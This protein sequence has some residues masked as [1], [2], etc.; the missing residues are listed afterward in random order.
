MVDQPMYTRLGIRLRE[1]R[2]AQN[3]SVRTL[4]SQ[5]GFS[6]SFISNIESETVSP[7]IASLEKIA[8]ALGVTLSE[9][10]S[11]LET[12]PRLIVRR[13]ERATSHSEWSKSS[14]AMLTDSSAGRQ[15]SAVEVT[16]AP[17]GASGSRAAPIAH[18]LFALVLDGAAEL[19][20]NRSTD[21]LAC[22]DAAYLKR[23]MSVVWRNT[24]EQQA[25]LLFVSVDDRAAQVVEMF[26]DPAA[27]TI[28]ERQSNQL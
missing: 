27:P 23:G 25:T 18:D 1:L 20:V 8:H 5:S 28:A 26:V 10:F 6:P 11:S 14:A 19:T 22:G 24:S 3:L 2:Q 17:S 12:A 13:H 7:S 9:L 21:T 4:A 16:L 15:L